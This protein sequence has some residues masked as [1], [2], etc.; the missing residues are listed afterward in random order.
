MHYDSE[1]EM[2]EDM[3]YQ[4]ICVDCQHEDNHSGEG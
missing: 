3:W 2:F 1:E 4:G